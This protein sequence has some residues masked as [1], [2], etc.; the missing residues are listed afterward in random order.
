MH[1]LAD[2]RGG[3]I[4]IEWSRLAGSGR[5]RAPSA[6]LLPQKSG[7]VE[8]EDRLLQSGKQLVTPEG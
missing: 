1:R 6:Y 3:M 5:N 4:L 8:E 2:Q 7:R